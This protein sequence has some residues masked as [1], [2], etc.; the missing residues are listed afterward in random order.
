M[1]STD[2]LRLPPM[3]NHGRFGINCV[4]HGRKRNNAKCLFTFDAPFDSFSSELSS[5]DLCLPLCPFLFR[6][7]FFVPA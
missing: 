7:I 6:E 1:I 4:L 2:Y 3:L 5:H